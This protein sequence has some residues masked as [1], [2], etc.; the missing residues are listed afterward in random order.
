MNDL[1]RK[2]VKLLKALQGITY[3]EISSYLEMNESSFNNWLKGL[4]NLGIERQLQ[5]DDII[6]NL[7]E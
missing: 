6:T 5:L 7:Q 4:Y 1:L 2:R 3:R